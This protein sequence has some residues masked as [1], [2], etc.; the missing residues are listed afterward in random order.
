[1]KR[2]TK[3]WPWILLVVAALLLATACEVG[4]DTDASTCVEIDVDAPKAK[5]PKPKIG[6]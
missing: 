2:F 3:H 6:R 1:M 5:K 4:G